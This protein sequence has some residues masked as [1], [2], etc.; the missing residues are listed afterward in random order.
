M[1]K[2]CRKFCF[3]STPKSA[4]K[5]SCMLVLKAAM[6]PRKSYLFI[7]IK[8]AKIYF[9]FR[10]IRTGR[11]DEILPPHLARKVEHGKRRS[12]FAAGRKV[13]G[14]RTFAVDGE[15]YRRKS[16]GSSTLGPVEEIGQFD[17]WGHRS[18]FWY[19]GVDAGCQEGMIKKYMMCNLKCAILNIHVYYFAFYTLIHIHSWA[20]FL[21]LSIW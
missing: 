6:K 14:W 15:I 17:V 21:F 8:Y 5:I 16:A 2:P 10:K 4:R 18:D 12:I 3:L 7:P 13:P 1:A 9:W 19:F 20:F 11:P